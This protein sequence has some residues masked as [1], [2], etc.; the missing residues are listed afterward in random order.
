[1]VFLPVAESLWKRFLCLGPAS[2]RIHPQT[3]TFKRERPP[4]ALAA[5][6]KRTGE[7]RI[8]LARQNLARRR[9]PPSAHEAHLLAVRRPE[10]HLLLDPQPQA[11]GLL[12][13]GRE[14]AVL[15]PPADPQG[16]R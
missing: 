11:R 13:P 10:A 4:P 2:R 5:C 12:P 16:A 1:M 14:I 3:V 15:A 7:R 8:A 6:E 9:G